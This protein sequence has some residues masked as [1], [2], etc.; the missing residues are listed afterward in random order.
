MSSNAPY[1]LT[2]SFA[3]GAEFVERLEEGSSPGVFFH[4]ST[5]E[6][7][8]SSALG[9]GALVALTIRFLDPVAE[10][11]VHAR[12][13]D[14]KVPEPGLWLEFLAEE[15]ERQELVCAFAEGQSV[16]YRRRGS[17]RVSTEVPVR[18]ITREGEAFDGHAINISARGMQLKISGSFETDSHVGLAISIAGQK[19][20][21]RV[22]AKVVAVVASGPQEGISVEFQFASSEARDAMMKLVASWPTAAQAGPAS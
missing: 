6:A 22:Q 17:T 16:A 19:D 21:L 5:D 7:L 9:A 20:P 15:A 13:V 18:A 4:R 14:R 12:V 11:Q 2:T 10:F 3:C 1:E 8:T